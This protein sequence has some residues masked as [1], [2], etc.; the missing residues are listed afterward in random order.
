MNDFLV[1]KDGSEAKEPW[2]CP[3]RHE[4]A[5]DVAIGLQEKGDPSGIQ[6]FTAHLDKDMA[7]DRGVL[8]NLYKTLYPQKSFFAWPWDPHTPIGAGREKREAARTEADL[9]RHEM[10]RSTAQWAQARYEHGKAT[11]HDYDPER[12]PADF[13]TLTRGALQA[14]TSVE[15]LYNV[16]SV[17]ADAD[18]F[19]RVAGHS[20]KAAAEMDPDA[21]KE[22][23]TKVQGC[24]REMAALSTREHQVRQ[25]RAAVAMR[26]IEVGIDAAL[27]ILAR[28]AGTAPSPREQQLLAVVAHE[29]MQAWDTWGPGVP[30]ASVDPSGADLP[31]PARALYQ[32]YEA[33]MSAAVS[34][35]KPLF[36]QDLMAGLYKA[37]VGLLPAPAPDF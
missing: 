17:L 5:L 31:E 14:K 7:V 36:P 25:A 35:G 13:E 6:S 8:K 29:M 10:Q 19:V 9:Q 4:K 11:G 33:R 20:G 24:L 34:P 32:K 2:I 28:R 21:V 16:V 12:L 1:R 15:R 26:V 30:I 18:G 23:P 27:E 22:L 3:E 37:I